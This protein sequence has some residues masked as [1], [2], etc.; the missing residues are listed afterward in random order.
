[1]NT[2]T[3]AIPTDSDAGLN[4]RR[5][6]HFGHSKMFTVVTM[7]DDTIAKVTSLASKPH[8]AGG[9]MSVIDYLWSNGVNTVIAGGMG[10]GPFLGLKNAGIA[11]LF[12]DSSGFPDVQSAIDGMLQGKLI[13][14]EMRQLCKGSGKC[15]ENE[16]SK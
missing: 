5:S 15:H 8:G 3:I 7:I 14:M 13:P 16:K 1:M 12:A 11:V 9:C 10:G 4:G 2:K 6:D